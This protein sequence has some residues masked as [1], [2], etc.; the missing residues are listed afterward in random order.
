MQYVDDTNNIIYKNN[1]YIKELEPYMNRYFKLT[2]TFY[3]L[4]K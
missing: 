2:E 1:N 3:N 4:N